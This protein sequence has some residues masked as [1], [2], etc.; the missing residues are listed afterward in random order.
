MSTSGLSGPLVYLEQ[1]SETV[2]GI[3]NSLSENKR[4]E[5]PSNK[6]VPDVSSHQLNHVVTVIYKYWL[7]LS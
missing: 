5:K 2:N 1:Y 6:R 7:F 4:K 3:V